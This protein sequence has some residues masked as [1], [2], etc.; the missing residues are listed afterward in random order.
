M[1]LACA[2]AR[3]LLLASAPLSSSVS[4]L[5]FDDDD[6]RHEMGSVGPDQP[7]SSSSNKSI[8]LIGA[9]LNQRLLLCCCVAAALQACVRASVVVRIIIMHRLLV[10]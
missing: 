5:W 4:L 6:D 7:V 8:E 2:C 3:A 10:A 1:V 9:W